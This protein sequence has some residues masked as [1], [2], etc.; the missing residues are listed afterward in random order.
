MFYGVCWGLCGVVEDAEDSKL[1]DCMI[2]YISW[3]VDFLSDQ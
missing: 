3:L 2:F 1:N